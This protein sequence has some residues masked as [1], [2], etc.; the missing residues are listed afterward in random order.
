MF[1]VNPRL[2]QLDGEPIY[3]DLQSL[4]EVPEA[5]SLVVPPA[6][7]EQIVQQAHQLGIRRVWMQP[8]SESAAAIEF[9]QQNDIDVIHSQCIMVLAPSRQK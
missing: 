4:P 3:P 6:I 1:G 2:N 9:C 7:S 8:G 5:I